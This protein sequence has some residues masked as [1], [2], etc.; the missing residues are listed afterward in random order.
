MGHDLALR[1]LQNN[2]VAEEVGEGGSVV[3]S[4]VYCFKF[5]KYEAKLNFTFCIF[6]LT[7]IDQP[8]LPLFWSLQVAHCPGKIVCL[9]D[10]A[11]RKTIPFYPEERQV[12]KST[13][14]GGGEGTGTTVTLS[15]S[16]IRYCN[17]TQ[18][19]A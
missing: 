11:R 18:P 2:I 14:G 3:E 19:K 15:H 1:S 7:F 17:A 12:C 8:R 13:A 10:T 5:S 6:A 9:A 4:L 16:V